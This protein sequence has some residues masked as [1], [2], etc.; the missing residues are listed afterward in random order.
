MPL[1]KVTLVR[2]G[3]GRGGK[4][5]FMPYPFCETHFGWWLYP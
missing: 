5:V 4:F 1:G 2:S 3:V